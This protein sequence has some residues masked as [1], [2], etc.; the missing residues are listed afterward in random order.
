MTAVLL[1]AVRVCF[2]KVD[3]VGGVKPFQNDLPAGIVIPTAK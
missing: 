3:L 1:F 2:Q